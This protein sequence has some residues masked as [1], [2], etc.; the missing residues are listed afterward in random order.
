ME[1]L[2]KPEIKHEKINIWRS[3]TPSRTQFNAPRAHDS[4]Q[5]TQKKVSFK[6]TPDQAISPLSASSIQS[7]SSISPARPLTQ[8]SNEDTSSSPRTESQLDGE[9]TPLLKK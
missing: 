4:F 7:Y 9:R 6:N 3:K 2:N 8:Q 1:I 5:T